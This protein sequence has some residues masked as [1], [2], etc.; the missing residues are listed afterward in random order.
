MRALP[1]ATG[2][3]CSQAEQGWNPHPLLTRWPWASRSGVL[4]AP[5]EWVESLASEGPRK[6]SEV[7]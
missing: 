2:E 6:R 3:L 1:Q 4:K 5:E 7:G